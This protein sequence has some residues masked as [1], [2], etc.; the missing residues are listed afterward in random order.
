MPFQ[1]LTLQELAKRL[2]IDARELQRLADRGSL[3]GH[4]VGGAW[5]FNQAQLLDWLQREMHGLHPAHQRNIERAMSE[6]DSSAVFNTRLALEAVD[7]RLRA[8][9]KP[10]V[11]RELVRLAANT[12][13]VQDAGHIVQAL[14]DREALCSTG[15]PGGIAFPHPRR[16]LPYATAEPLLA[17]ARVQGGMPF[18]APDG[19]LTDIFVLVCCHDERQHLQSLARLSLMFAGDLADRLREIDDNEAALG[20]V[21]EVERQTVG[22]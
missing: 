2:G 6:G 5:R 12:G 16:P 21:L 15:L 9:T 14:E 17:L 18:G 19:K 13:L 22:G 8:R 20:L 10:S 11:L 3:P 7:M 4:R 1:N